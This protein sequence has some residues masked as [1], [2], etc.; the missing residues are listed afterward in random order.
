MN[1]RVLDIHKKQG[2]GQSSLRVNPPAPH[3]PGLSIVTI[4]RCVPD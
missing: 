2:C 3:Y 1:D 4:Y